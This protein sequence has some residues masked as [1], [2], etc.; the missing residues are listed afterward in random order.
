MKKITITGQ[1]LVITETE[2]EVKI[3]VYTREGLK[4]RHPELFNLIGSL[5]GDCDVLW[6]GDEPYGCISNGCEPEGRC[7]LHVQ[8]HGQDKV[9][10]CDCR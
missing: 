5:G 3:A 6:S 4:D 8:N 7:Y 9:A 1:V 2:N 10:W